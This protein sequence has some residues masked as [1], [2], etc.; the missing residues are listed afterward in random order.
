LAQPTCDDAPATFAHAT[1]LSSCH[2]YDP[3]AAAQ[4][5]DRDGWA[6]GADGYR[7]RQGN[8]LE[9][10]Y[11]FTTADVASPPAARLVQQQ[12]KQVGIK[13]DLDEYKADALFHTVLP[14]GAFDLAEYA[15]APREGDPANNR[16]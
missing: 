6:L 2:T 12:L 15:I 14:S 13:P 4:L 7:H 8:V 5:L 3:G 10:R 9:L 16:Q 1:D 11:A